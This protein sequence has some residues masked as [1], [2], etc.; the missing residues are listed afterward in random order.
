MVH[1][2]CSS[3]VTKLQDYSAVA[4]EVVRNSDYDEQRRGAA[5]NDD[6]RLLSGKASIFSLFLCHFELYTSAN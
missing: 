2:H 6:C 4:Q 3:E 5:G 1:P